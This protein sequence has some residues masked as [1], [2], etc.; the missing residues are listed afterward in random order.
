MDLNGSDVPPAR[1]KEY[2]DEF[3][4]MIRMESGNGI[5]DSPVEDF[6]ALLDQMIMEALDDPT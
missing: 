4:Q 2:S 6:I 5:R 1:P 3:G